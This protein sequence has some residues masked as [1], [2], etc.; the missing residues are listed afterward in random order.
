[1]SFDVIHENKIL[2]KNSESAV[3]KLRKLIMG[4]KK[5]QQMTKKRA[6]LSSTQELK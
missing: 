6:K 2:A 4:M 3:Y 5:N 1:M